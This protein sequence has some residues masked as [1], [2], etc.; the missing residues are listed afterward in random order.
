[1]IILLVI[2]LVLTYVT[3]DMLYKKNTHSK[4]VTL[5][6]LAFWAS[7]FAM[8][9]FGFSFLI[10]DDVFANFTW[11]AFGW[12]VLRTVLGALSVITWVG[13]VKYL[14]VSIGVSLQPARMFPLL[15][16]GVFIFG[17]AVGLPAILIAVALFAFCL[18]LGIIQY[19]AERAAANPNYWKGFMWLLGWLL[20]A[21]PKMAILRHIGELDVNIILFISI[22]CVMTLAGSFACLLLTRT[23]IRA[24]FKTIVRD[25]KMIPLGILDDWW[26]LLYLPLVMTMN[27]GVLEAIMVSAVAL[28]VL[29][30]VVLLRERIR[31]TAYPIIAAI[32]ACAVALALL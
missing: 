2:P 27:I 1:M 11:Q 25:P 13:T 16:I 8:V 19:R 14:P 9:A 20:V 3:I 6:G 5:F 29:A 22:V 17:D 12:I 30:G 15:V 10:F 32:I 31:W 4:M 24:T 18:I 28:T 23:S 21:T 26:V 7:A